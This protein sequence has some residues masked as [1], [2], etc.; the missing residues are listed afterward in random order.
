MS[1]ELSWSA[2]WAGLLPCAC[3]SMVEDGGHVNVDRLVGEE[4]PRGHGGVLADAVAAILGLPRCAAD[5]G[6]S[7]NSTSL[8]ACK[9][10]PNPAALVE[11]TITQH[12]SS[13][14]KRWTASWR[15]SWLSAAKMCAQPGRPRA[16]ACWV[17]VKQ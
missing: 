10:S 13:F 16:R 15:S 8:A 9:V 2:S 3:W 6:R 14:W 1:S 5:Q 4:E 12:P 7:M 11:H 17:S